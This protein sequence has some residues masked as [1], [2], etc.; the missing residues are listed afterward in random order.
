MLHAFPTHVIARHYFREMLADNVDAIG[1]ASQMTVTVDGMLHK[2]LVVD[3]PESL[4]AAR[5]LCPEALMLHSELRMD[6]AEALIMLTRTPVWGR[7]EH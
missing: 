1:N 6:L 3:T 2:F 5:G 4:D 7:A